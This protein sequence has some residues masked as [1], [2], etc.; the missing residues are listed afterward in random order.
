MSHRIVSKLTKLFQKDNYDSDLYAPLDTSTPTIRL[1]SLLPERLEGEIRVELKPCSLNNARDR[2][3]TLSYTWGDADI[4]ASRLIRCNGRLTSISENLYTALRTLRLRDSP[5]L[6]WAD[7]L[8][9]NQDDTSE[10]TLQVGLMAE[11]YRNSKETVIWLGNPAA[12]EDVG[13]DVLRGYT[14][15]KPFLQGTWTGGSR[16]EELR[17]A[18]LVDFNW[19]NAT[20]MPTRSRSLGTD[21]GPDIFGAFCLIQDFAEGSS[22]PLLKVLDREKV[23]ALQRYGITG[24]WSG[25]VLA[26]GHVRGSRSSQVWEGL[27]RLMSRSWVHLSLTSLYSKLTVTVATCLGRPRD[28]VISQSYYSIWPALGTLAD[29]C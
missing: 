7:A 10:R 29:V 14:S 3:T 13:T 6:L 19:S 18:Y 9:I 24:N 27:A 8:C 4:V 5:L 20:G 26:N 16:D 15:Y 17:K 23:H 11:I 2:Y 25:L 28:C 1:L 21:P 22:Y 12:N